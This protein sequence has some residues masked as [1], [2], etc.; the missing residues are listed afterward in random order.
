MSDF[1]L[2]RPLW[3]ILA[4]LA[5]ALIPLAL[6]LAQRSVRRARALTRQPHKP[7]RVATVALALAVALAA[8]A[9][10]QP[11]WGER[12]VTLPSGGAQLVAVL[13]VSRSMGVADVAP[14]R[15]AAARTAIADA[16]RGLSGDRAALVVFAGDARV[17]FPLTHDLAAAAAV[18]ESVEGGT[19]LLE[20]GTSAAA[21][22]DLARE[23]FDDED[24]RAGRLVLLVSDGDDLAGDAVASAAALAD[25]GVALL[26]AGAGTP[27]GGVVPAFDPISGERTM[28]TDAGGAPVVSR[29]DEARLRA[30]A[31][32]AGGRYLGTGLASVPGAVRARLAALEGGERVVVTVSLPV[33][34]FQWFAA[35]ALAL[36]LLGTAIEWRALPR[37]RYGTA[38][39]A[40]AVPVAL[41][42]AACATAAHD[43]NERARAALEAGDVDAA[44]ELLYEA[45]AED[46]ADGRIALNLAAALHRAER[47]EEGASMARIAAANRDAAIA[48]AGHASLGRHLF[49]MDALE[50]SLAAFGEALLLTPEDDVA[51]RDYE[52]V[53][54][55]LQSTPPET[56]PAPA[57]GDADPP[58]GDP[59][60]S[61]ASQPAPGADGDAASGGD[62]G[63]AGG[64]ERLA[65]AALEA[66]LA[67]L[68]AR[69]AE[70]R[71][72]A[73]ET[74]S[75]EEALAILD[76]LAERAR[77]AARNAIR[78]RWN[79]PGD[80]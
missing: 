59:P 21:G 7:R 30:I 72:E 19:L 33:E 23:L 62:G 25:A 11:R 68:D 73:G 35:A 24:A 49:A 77:L 48:S 40:A 69:V 43:L 42:A 22:L 51:R 8:V 79:D 29:L 75:A 9:A 16:F 12:V 65:P 41:L 6:A 47:Y 1:G 27:A 56:V 39:A 4:P 80:Y 74:L 3:L 64:G 63:E 15:L 34:R 55:L 32:A 14:S 60:E 57:E 52:V 13:D 54:R 17:R 37:W 45:R 20:R 44:V 50:D 58:E 2:G 76:L 53:Y 70:L 71:A 46:P 28:L 18:V 10:A 78:A 5:L 26:V 61:E 67:A 38:L 31:G 36:A 66:E